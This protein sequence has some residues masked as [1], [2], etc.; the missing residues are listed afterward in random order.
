MIELKIWCLLIQDVP[1]LLDQ[2]LNML[3]ELQ[4]VHL[5]AYLTLEPC[6][7]NSSVL[8]IGRQIHQRG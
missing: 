4:V 7:S 5:V 8:G 3:T 2:A 6:R 1:F